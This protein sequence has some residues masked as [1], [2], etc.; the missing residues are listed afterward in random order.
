MYMIHD[1]VFYGNIF[2]DILINDNI[3]K[4]DIL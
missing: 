4:I 1:Y 2:I 3:C